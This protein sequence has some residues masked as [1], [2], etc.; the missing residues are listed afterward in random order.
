MK[1]CTFD[2]RA[3]YAPEIELGDNERKAFRWGGHSTAVLKYFVPYLS[4]EG[5]TDSISIT[6]EPERP[7]SIIEVFLSHGR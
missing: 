6:V 7:Y 3:Y 2:L 4:G 5:F 1:E